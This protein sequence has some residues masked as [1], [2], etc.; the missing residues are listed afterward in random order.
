MVSIAIG[1]DTLIALVTFSVRVLTT[2]RL[3]STSL[4]VDGVAESQAVMLLT[5]PTEWARN[6]NT[7]N[8]FKVLS[9]PFEA[10]SMGSMNISLK[11]VSGKVL[12]VKKG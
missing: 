5:M 11:M 8:Q 2:M 7:L 3:L 12:N 10:K 6:G 4:W 9:T 1:M